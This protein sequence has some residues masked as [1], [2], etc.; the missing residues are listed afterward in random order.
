MLRRVEDS[1]LSLPEVIV[2]YGQSSEN[3]DYDLVHLNLQCKGDLLLELAFRIKPEANGSLFAHGAVMKI[4]RL[5][6]LAILSQGGS[7]P[8]Y[9]KK[10]NQ[11]FLSQE[12]DTKRIEALTRLFDSQAYWI[13]PKW[14]EQ[15]PMDCFYNP[16]SSEDE[17]SSAPEDDDSK[18]KAS[19]EDKRASPKKS[20]PRRDS[21]PKRTL[22]KNNKDIEK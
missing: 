9:N 10:I 16:P 17:S 13:P 8:D 19:S 21:S 11:F 5:L 1:C 2:F 6:P 22:A 3:P 18:E 12:T 14:M 4:E 15:L 20:S 7:I